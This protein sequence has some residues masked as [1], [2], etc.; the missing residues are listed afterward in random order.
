M[1]LRLKLALRIA[2]L[3][4]AAVL[5]ATLVALQA[6]RDN[7]TRVLGASQFALVSARADEIDKAMSVRVRAVEGVAAAIPGEALASPAGAT[8]ALAGR[9]V[10]GQLFSSVILLSADGRLLTIAPAKPALVGVDFADREYFKRARDTR[11]VAVSEPLLA[12]VGSQPQVLIAA[13]VFDANGVFRGE[14]LGTLDI[15][16]DE[17]LGAMAREK[18][19][20]SGYFAVFTLHG[21]TLISHPDASRV[22]VKGRTPNAL[23][24]RALAGWEGSEIGASTAGT[25]AL[26]SF[27]HLKTVPWLVA[28]VLPAAEAFAPIE[29]ARR[30]SFLAAGLVALASGLLGWWLIAWQARPLLE[31]QREITRASAEPDYVPQ[32][33]SRR[34]DELGAVSRGFTAL[35]AQRAALQDEL[36]AANAALGGKLAT[37]STELARQEG[38][39]ESFLYTLGHD[40]R[41]P[42]RAVQGFASVVA[43]DNAGKLDAE[44]LRLLGRIIASGRLMSG[45]VDG[46]IELGRISK[47][48]VR[49]SLPPVAM[50]ALLAD[51]IRRGAIPSGLVELP[52][53]PLPV[54]RGDPRLVQDVWDALLDNAVKFSAA[55]PAPRIRIGARQLD[56]AVEYSVSDNGIGF[57]TAYTESV[58]RP[59]SR[60]HTEAAYEGIGLGLTIAQRALDKM[61]GTIRC[62]SAP[63]AGAT[64]FFTLPAAGQPAAAVPLPAVATPG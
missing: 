49:E 12:R 11:R 15:L 35:M 42:L 41:A 7:V 20:Q 17:V 8:A 58:F 19:G 22:M 64:F 50:H 33:D 38:E 5:G 37:R 59:F 24:Q 34:A 46:M 28:A 43:E 16:A 25:R 45:L 32:L 4:A 3:M 57:D 30:Q 27:R 51:V 6:Q 60:L 48:E 2:V 10:L 55:A 23:T 36:R 18:I 26:M 61:G 13:P 29:Q 9:P 56:R 62:E 53:A 54:A 52:A 39:M 63:G 31:M 47:F 14:L 40:L 1:S 44:S 21:P